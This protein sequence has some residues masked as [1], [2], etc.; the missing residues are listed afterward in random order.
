MTEAW[1]A[2]VAALIAGIVAVAGSFIGV[3]VGRRQV[4]DEAQIEHEQW[5]RGQRQEAY[6]AFLA[7]WDKAYLGMRHEVARLTEQ[8]EAMED[9]G[10]DI[11]AEEQDL[12]HAREFAERLMQPI[13]EVL[14]RVLLLGPD[15]VDEAAERMGQALD[16]LRAAFVDHL[17]PIAQPRP[18][19]RWPEAVRRMEE[20][21]ER[22]I[23]VMRAEVRSAPTV[24]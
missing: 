24:R 6:A 4:R 19:V 9:H 7:E 20:A 15:V 11:S 16:V 1:G 17:A 5:L 18:A 10:L 13:R 3:Y 23:S 12:E 14:E 21:R 2:V 8:W 22:M